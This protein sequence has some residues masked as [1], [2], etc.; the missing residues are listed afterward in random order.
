MAVGRTE[1][2]FVSKLPGLASVVNE[3]LEDD[4]LLLEIWSASLLH[5]GL[6]D[7]S[8]SRRPVV[9]SPPRERG[10]CGKDQSWSVLRK[11]VCS[12]SSITGPSPTSNTQGMRTSWD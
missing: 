2:S 12:A 3:F 8:F 9:D 7:K 11:P 4:D 10:V 5:Q 1:G 6:H